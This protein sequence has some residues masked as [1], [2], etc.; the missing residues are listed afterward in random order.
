MTNRVT[1][2]VVVCLAANPTLA[3]AQTTMNPRI[4]EFDPSP[5]HNAVLPSGLPVV[6]RYVLEFYFGGA[7]QPF[8]SLNLAKPAPQ[9]DGKIRVDFS[10]SVPVLPPSV[11]YEARVATVGVTGMAE[12]GPSNTFMFSGSTPFIDPT[13][14][15]GV[16]VV[17][18]VHLT[19]LRDRIDAQR[20]RFG[21]APF[22][23]TD[24]AL[25]APVMIKA[26]HV[27]EMRTAL[28]QAYA[29]HGLTLPSYVD[30]ALTPGTVAVKVIHI[31][32]LRNAVVSLE[33]AP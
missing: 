30:S 26:V 12:S 10:A 13:L 20:A 17:K 28:G 2:L 24:G 15:P 16:T 25:G 8:Q 23:W 32:E 33:A 14:L 5:D 29:A 31:Q 7:A 27:A 22:A 11:L 9:S 6:D 21:L 4:V 18:R 19:E 1:A 3:R